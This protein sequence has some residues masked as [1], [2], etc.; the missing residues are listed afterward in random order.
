MKEDARLVGMFA[1][2]LAEWDSIAHAAAMLNRQAAW[3]W[4]VFRQICEDL[5]VPA[6]KD[7][8]LD[9]RLT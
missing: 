1:G 5:G 8:D 6:T 9:N 3:G 4:E 2:Y 7:G